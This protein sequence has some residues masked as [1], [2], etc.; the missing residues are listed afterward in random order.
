[1]AE[2]APPVDIAS[3]SFSNA[4]RGFDPTEVRAFLTQLAT[5]LAALKGYVAKLEVQL[6]DA[7]ERAMRPERLDDEMLVARLGEETGRVIHAARRGADDI[8]N[9]G[10]EAAEQLRAEAQA[11]ALRVREEAHLGAQRE[12]D[13]A[14][15]Q[16]TAIV[17]DAKHQGREMLAEAQAVRERVLADLARRRN[18]GRAQL[19]Q[20]RT[21]RDRL[22][23]AFQHA[24]DALTE[25]EAGLRAA[26]PE[27]PPQGFPADAEPVPATVEPA[28]AVALPAAPQAVAGPLEDEAPEDASVAASVAE[29][30]ARIR[31]A[32][33]DDVAEPPSAEVVDITEAPASATEAASKSPTARA[34]DPA[35]STLFAQ[36]DTAVAPVAMTLSKRLKRVVAD[37]QNEVLD[38]LRRITKLRTLDDVLPSFETHA[39]R[40]YAA[41][42]AELWSAALAGARETTSRDDASLAMVLEGHG[43]PV[44]IEMEVARQL[45][46]PLRERTA[47]SVSDAEGDAEEAASLLRA[48]YR[49]W[50]VQRVEAIT[51]HLALAAYEFGAYACLD[52]GTCV[53]W[54]VDPA[55]S[56]CA[57]AED[58]ALAG[59]VRVG[60]PFPTGHLHAPAYPGCR[61]R[62]VVEH[63][64]VGRSRLA[65]EVPGHD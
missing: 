33:V 2:P 36:R 1:M 58:N 63:V 23:V 39:E 9:R 25:V 57:D 61:C 19:E 17:E 38:A 30:F 6:A 44:A 16:G 48:A 8:R 5:E 55:A 32:R 47:K 42:R 27:A 15:R 13:D 3:R 7:E 64:V 28:L 56:P 4:F 53:R 29:L 60:D 11:D 24:Y 26:A 31:A 35:V 21:G 20:L 54:L 46:S 18:A 43:V 51:A 10:A 34:A 41:V 52:P 62:V 59:L 45:V 50:K 40:Y 49:E 22:L 65:A 14:Q 37:E 12:L